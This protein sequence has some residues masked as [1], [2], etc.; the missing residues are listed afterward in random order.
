MGKTEDM[1]DEMLNETES[2]FI[3]SDDGKKERTKSDFAPNVDGEF[4]G[5]LQE[6]SCKEVSWTKQG[7]KY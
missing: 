5:H 3:P 2:F 6:A 7:K 1:F 4:L